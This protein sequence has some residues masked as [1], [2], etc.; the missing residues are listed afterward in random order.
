M[1]KK[2]LQI[3]IIVFSGF[4]LYVLE[5]FI[6]RTQISDARIGNLI[7]FSFYFVSGM[8]IHIINC[9]SNNINNYF[10][11]LFL[12]AA[13]FFD[14]ITLINNKLLFPIIVP[15]STLSIT[16]GFYLGYNVAKRNRYYYIVLLICF[17]LFLYVSLNSI[18][19]IEY[20]QQNDVFTAETKQVN[21]TLLRTQTNDTIDRR[22]LNGKVVLL[23]FY[24]QHCKPCC[25]KFPTLEKLKLAFKGRNDVE[26]I[27]VYCDVDNSIRELPSFLERFKIT[28]TT[29]IDKD[30][31]LCKELGI[32]SFPMEVLVNKKGEIVSTYW[33]FQMGASDK[34]YSERVKLINELLKND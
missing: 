1:N 24:F 30:L 26:I 25:E 16:L 31:K 22:S 6:V 2:F 7:S 14:V 10:V 5:N 23:D 13:L 32:K 15:I 9:K 28:I 33:G 18:A 21:Y 34:Y 27:G 3:V 11:Y 20:K 17:P 12:L 8:L 4:G 29:L 19:N